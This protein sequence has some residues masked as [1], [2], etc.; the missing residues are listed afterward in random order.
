[1]N[2]A[3]IIVVIT[4]V[5]AAI[6]ELIDTSIVNVGLSQMAGTLGVTIEDI[7][8]VITS[9]AIAN[10]VI[11]PMTGFFQ[12]YFGRKN[13][14]LASIA[15]FTIA[16][17]FCGTAPDLWTLVAWRFVQGIGGGALLSVSQGILFDTFS[18]QQRPMASAMFGIGVVLGPTFGP[19]LGGIIIDNYHWSW[20]FF[21]NLPFGILALALSWFFIEKKPEEFN[22]DRS[23][24]KIDT[25]GIVLL[26]L[27]IG[28]MEFVLERGAADDWFQ[29]MNILRLTILCIVSLVGFIW[30][31]LRSPNP[32]VDLRVL[33]NRNL[34]IGL[35]LTV[36]VGFGLFGSVFLYPLF[37][38]RIIGF[39]ART[40][41]ELIIP[42]AM[43]ALFLF[44]IVGKMTTR[45]VPPRNIVFVG[46]FFFFLFT[47]LMS[48]L[49]AEAAGWMLAA[50]LVVRG[51]G[52]AFLNLPLINSSVSTL[53]PQQL[54][55]GIA[56]TNMFRQLG[57][58]LGIAVLNTFINNRAA[59]HRT[60]LVSN[61]VQGSPAFDERVNGIV[62]GVVS[63]GY[64]PLDA[65]KVAWQSLDLLMQKQALMLSY[66][67][68]FQLTALFFVVSLPL[69]LLIEKKKPSAEAVKAAAEA[70]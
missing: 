33:K 36:V 66:L 54:P 58:A 60:D 6:M 42:G 2:F 52:L 70:H 4:V 20:M 59:Q 14:Y 7:S 1:M 35:F 51:I 64:N 30:W 44:P 15:L 17:V 18:I 49:N 5:S 25:L 26:A 16:S 22:I 55:M 21:I 39:G 57:G 13:Y 63:R 43:I 32:V 56:M 61:Y 45:G 19:T 29:D 47:M 37:A 9:Y 27:C 3:K 38:Q 48:Q 12:R 24:I 68:A 40:T 31:E 10:V 8:W 23:K 46:Y 65:P 53:T 50:V 28:P 34:A 69:I 62:G 67:D 11:I 41:G